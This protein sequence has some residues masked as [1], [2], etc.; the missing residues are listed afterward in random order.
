[1][2]TV[3]LWIDASIDAF[4]KRWL[5]SRVMHGDSRDA[6]TGYVRLENAALAHIGGGVR[7]HM[8]ASYI[9]QSGAPHEPLAD[10]VIS[11]TIAADGPLLIEVAM[12]CQDFAPSNLAKI[13]EQWFDEMVDDIRAAWGQEI[14]SERE[15]VE[16][17]ENPALAQLDMQIAELFHTELTYEQIGRQLGISESTVKRSTAR[18]GLYRRRRREKGL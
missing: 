11:F 13:V 4:V 17:W 10:K 7:I 5:W 16:A 12:Q 8:D 1:M 3:T 15:A 2:K 6:R 14:R 18:Q 9:P